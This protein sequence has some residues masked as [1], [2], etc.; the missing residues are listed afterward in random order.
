MLVMLLFGDKK[1]RWLTLGEGNIEKVAIIRS[2]NSWI[3]ERIR[4]F[5]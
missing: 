3:R 2:G 4:I 1:N 5:I